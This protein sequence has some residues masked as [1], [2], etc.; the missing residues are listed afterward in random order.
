[1]HEGGIDNKQK[2]VRIGAAMTL[3][4]FCKST[5]VRYEGRMTQ[6]ISK[7]FSRMV[8]EDDEALQAAWQALSSVLSVRPES[9]RPNVVAKPH[10]TR[11]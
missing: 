3:S 11:R 5:S 6:L 4:D 1:M 10:R 8:D 7:L 9:E 2:R